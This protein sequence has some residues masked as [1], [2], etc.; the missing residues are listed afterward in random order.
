MRGKKGQVKRAVVSTNLVLSLQ[1]IV[2]ILE[3]ELLVIDS[4]YRVRFA[5]LAG[6]GMLGEGT[7]S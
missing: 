1:D 5:K 6:Q 7:E 4:E 3:D 2:E